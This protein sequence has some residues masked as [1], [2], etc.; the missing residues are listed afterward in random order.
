MTVHR[1]PKADAIKIELCD[2][3]CGGILVQLIAYDGRVLAFGSISVELA[4]DISRDLLAKAAIVTAR[5]GPQ[6]TH[7]GGHA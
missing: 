6:P 5:G 3:G 1:A 7:A 2:C 4:G